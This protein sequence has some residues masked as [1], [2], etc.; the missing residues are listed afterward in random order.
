MLEVPTKS[1]LVFAVLLTCFRPYI[2]DL[3]GDCGN[4][5]ANTLELLQSCADPLIYCIT[6]VG[7]LHSRLWYH[8]FQDKKKKI[9]I[10]TSLSDPVSLFINSLSE[11]ISCKKVESLEAA[12]FGFTILQLFCNVTGILAAEK[13]IKFQSGTVILTPSISSTRLHVQGLLQ[14]YPRWQGSWGQHGAHLGPVGPRLA[15]WTLLSGML[16][17]LLTHWP[18][19][20]FGIGPW[21]WNRWLNARLQ[22]LHC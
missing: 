21:K 3:A 14:N 22:Y 7:V 4:S 5:I 6:C 12:R 1:L 20:S 19:I 18:Y 9:A 10:H 13:P 8:G 2:D 15:P 16:Y 17:P 11:W